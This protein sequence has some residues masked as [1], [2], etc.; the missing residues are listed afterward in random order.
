MFII[1]A[2][3]LLEADTDF[4]CEE[5][6]HAA[7][8]MRDDLMSGSLSKSRIDKP[9]HAGACFVRP[10]KCEPDFKLGSF[11]L[12]ILREVGASHRVYPDRQVVLRHRLKNGIK[13]R[14][15]Q[16]FAEDVGKY[17]DAA[18]VQFG[19][20]AV[21][22][23]HGCVRII[24]RQRRDKPCNRSGFVS[25]VRQARR[26]LGGQ[27]RGLFRR[28]EHFY[29]RIGER[30][31]LAIIIEPVKHSLVRV[32]VMQSGQCPKNLMTFGSGATSASFSK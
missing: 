28:S 17:L 11:L 1:A 31:D 15:R 13:L 10:A 20:G 29:R 25:H 27:G 9:G 32:Y 23:G 30:D 7:E 16:R 6:D 18:G 5:R 4:F 19:H 12:R 24:H 8:M 22:L 2:E 14:C 21:C 3:Y 26:W